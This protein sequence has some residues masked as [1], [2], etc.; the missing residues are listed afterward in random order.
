MKSLLLFLTLLVGGNFVLDW[1][2]R[3]DF[4]TE[5][6]RAGEL[7]EALKVGSDS[8]RRDAA[9]LLETLRLQSNAFEK[10]VE[11]LTQSFESLRTFAR[12]L[13]TKGAAERASEEKPAAGV[14]A[15]DEFLDPDKPVPLSKVPELSPDVILRR[16]HTLRNPGNE[17]L[18]QK[19]TQL[20]DHKAWES[21]QIIAMF[22][23]EKIVHLD[24]LSREILNCEIEA[25]KQA[26]IAAF[27][28][29]Q[30][31]RNLLLID[32]I[33]MGDYEVANEFGEFNGPEAPKDELIS[34][35]MFGN[36]RIQWL[37]SD[38]PELY[39]LNLVSMYMPLAM[40]QAVDRFFTE[41]SSK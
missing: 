27:G 14:G 23:E 35:A 38:Y 18:A 22:E 40:V 20:S 31:Q 16:I 10:N 37:R 28:K 3:F 19:Y 21:Q 6:R 33:E 29:Y 9:I 25:Y 15:P 11:S 4:E 24:P 36:K 32:R 34:F 39:R 30:M 12:H 1:W 41:G 13:E 5:K 7:I 2:R 8:D 17:K 26:A